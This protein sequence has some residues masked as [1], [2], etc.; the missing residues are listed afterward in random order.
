MLASTATANDRVVAD[1]SEQLGRDLLV[2]RGTLDRD[3]PRAAGHRPARSAARLAWLAE[4]VP[5]LPGSG[6]VYCLTITDVERVA[7][8]LCDHGV[9]AVA[10]SGA[11]DPAER[12]AI[13]ARLSANDVKVVVATS[14]LGMGYDKPD[15]TFVVHYQ[16]PGSPI[17]LLP[18]GR[19]G[20]ARRRPGRRRA[21]VRPRGRRHPGLLHLHGVPTARAGRARRRPPRRRGRAGDPRR[22]AV[23]GQHR[24]H[25]ADRDAQGAR[26]RGRRPR[27]PGR[28][29][30]GSAPTSRGP[31]TP[32]G[33][34]T[35][36]ACAAPSSRRCA[37]TPR[38]TAA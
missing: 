33:S 25:P 16:S 1:V 34:T 29:S 6:I 22:A 28:R 3:S 13:E 32:T 31:T 18:A 30:S 5:T 2:Q 20:R 14:A 17:A 26:R 11:T 8:W 15:L 21:A 27:R 9:D 23:A 10:Y 4:Q 7:D 12:E 24:L 37:T 38:P 36:R 19:P 35:S